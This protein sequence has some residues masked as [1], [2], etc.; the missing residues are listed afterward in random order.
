MDDECGAPPAFRLPCV[1]M[2]SPLTA[3]GEQH[4]C[5]SP[6]RPAPR[7]MTLPPRWRSHRLALV[8]RAI[9]R[10]RSCGV[11]RLHRLERKIVPRRPCNRTRATPAPPPDMGCSNICAPPFSSLFSLGDRHG[12]QSTGLSVVRYQLRECLRRPH[13]ATHGS[14]MAAPHP[15]ALPVDGT[16]APSALQSPFQSFPDPTRQETSGRPAL[17]PNSPLPPY[18]HWG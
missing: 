8:Q 4:F 14:K 6:V 17:D 1:P 11:R 3:E 2:P 7:S 12:R 5:P 15:R 9:R 10:Q 18:L 13:A 16:T